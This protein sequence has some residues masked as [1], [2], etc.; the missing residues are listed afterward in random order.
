M[1]LLS[2]LPSP[3]SD[4]LSSSSAI[5]LLYVAVGAV[6]TY[7]LFTWYLSWRRLSHIPGP[8]GAGW[9]K[10]W[11][12]RNT[13]GGNMHLALKQA[14]E[15]H[16][17]L[18]R[19]GPNVLITNDPDTL[20]RMWG[21][22]S[23]WKKA[24]WYDAVRW[25]PT[26]DNLISQRDD[27]KHTA[28]R[29][30]MAAGYSGKENEGL[31]RTIDE[32][33][34]EFMDL[35]ERKYLSSDG[36]FRPMD[37]ARKIQYFTLDTISQLAFGKNFGHVRE[38]RDVYQYIKITEESMPV[39]L[40]LT[41]FPAL[42]RM[43]QSRMMR[44][45]LPS[46]KDKV[47]FGRFIGVAK[48]VVAERLAS[49]DP[50]RKDMLGS[51][52]AH[53]LT[54]VEAEGETL[55]QIIAGSD[56]TATAIRTTLLFLMTNPGCYAKLTGE[57][58]EADRKHVISEPITNVEAQTLLPYLQAV[59]KEGLRRFPPVTGTMNTEVPEGGAEICGYQVPAGTDVGWSAVAIQHSKVVYGEDAELFRPERWLE[60]KG[61]DLKNMTATLDMVFKY[62]KWQCLGK[63][64]ALIEL[65][66]IFVE[67][68]RRYDFSLVD[69]TN[70]WYSYSAG[71]FIQHGLNVRVTRVAK[72][73]C[74]GA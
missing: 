54:R 55:T 59:I 33:I 74:N 41:V 60:A 43:L 40:I 8:A 3:L 12:L 7:N 16:G 39:M 42:A 47:G 13:L 30:K 45:L 23:P 56:T 46:E 51:F 21:V 58:R 24:D 52:L 65:N 18:V 27:D 5:Q 15:E 72:A 53:G 31:E 28:L 10:W 62:G 4:G 57:I 32:Q 61:E 48:S 20:R 25:D 37:F 14:C 1:T 67:L 44:G 73:Y 36:E 66:K 50:Y 17:P 26:K 9:S 63:N 68:L 19:V 64:V 11:L 29:A 38:D 2:A 6:V 22:R 70:P 35:I 69:P 34:L 49:D 71:I